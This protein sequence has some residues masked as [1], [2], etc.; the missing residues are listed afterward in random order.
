[1][2]SAVEDRADRFHRGHKAAGDLAIDFFE[3]V[4][5]EFGLVEILRKTRPVRMD[6]ANLLLHFGG[7]PFALEALVNSAIKLAQRATKLF[8][9]SLDRRPCGH[10]YQTHRTFTNR[11]TVGR[12]F[13]RDSI[14]RSRPASINQSDVE[15]G[16]SVEDLQCFLAVVN[17]RA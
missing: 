13:I 10:R 8:D 5:P 9:R 12:T 3:A 16:N 11:P 4:G 15:S 1:M 2:N 7:I 17:G 6:A 14:G